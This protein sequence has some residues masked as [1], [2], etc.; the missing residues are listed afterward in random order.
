MSRDRQIRR[1]SERFKAG[2]RRAVG[3]VYG[4]AGKERDKEILDL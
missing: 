2:L 4:Q 1:E 3:Q